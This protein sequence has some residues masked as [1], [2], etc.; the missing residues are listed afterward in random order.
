MRLNEIPDINDILGEWVEVNPDF[1][2]KKETYDIEPELNMSEIINSYSDKIYTKK[3]RLNPYDYDLC[4]YDKKNNRFLGYIEC[5]H[6]RYN[7]L[8]INGSNWKH[9]F[10]QRKIFVYENGNGFRNQIIKDNAEKTI[11]FKMSRVYGLDDCICCNLLDITYFDSEVESKTG[12][13]YNDWF[14]R[15]SMENKKVARGI[16]EC[17][18]YIEKY[19]RVVKEE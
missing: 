8:G 4:C 11:Y 16:Y 13:D 14:L 1:D 2:L 10:L 18:R 7:K 5:E 6:S 3:N 19:F 17:I 12:N 9:S 15:T